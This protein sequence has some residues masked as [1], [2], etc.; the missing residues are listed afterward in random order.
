M[1]E[2]SV[3]SVKP[4]LSD[5]N[6]SKCPG[7]L[8]TCEMK[9]LILKIYCVCMECCFILSLSSFFFLSVVS[10]WV[11]VFSKANSIAALLPRSRS[12]VWSLLMNVLYSLYY[13]HWVRMGTHRFCKSSSVCCT[14]L[15]YPSI[16]LTN[17][18]SAGLVFWF[19]TCV[20]REEVILPGCCVPLWSG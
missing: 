19:K 13:I 10:E 5:H 15:L 18:L 17:P 7:E 2:Q 8:K 16:F 9:N 4:E 6:N 12:C 14:H 3:Q 11:L 20:P 1:K